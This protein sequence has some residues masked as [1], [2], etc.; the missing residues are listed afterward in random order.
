MQLT[1]G[2]PTPVPLAPTVMSR[3]ATATLGLSK[4]EMGAANAIA[5]AAA[6]ALN[7]A[8]QIG[9]EFSSLLTMLLGMAQGDDATPL[10]D[11]LLSLGP[12]V[13]AELATP[14]VRNV[15]LYVHQNTP[16]GD[17]VASVIEKIARSPVVGI[18]PDEFTA[19]DQL[20]THGILP[21][22]LK[23]RGVDI[24]ND[25]VPD[26]IQCPHCRRAFVP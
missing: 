22:L 18:N 2:V 21:K 14:V 3:V 15:L 19:V 5:S 24:D 20:I 13:L 9:N 26:L 25:G 16:Y 6:P 12:D 1:R 11:K 8:P 7:V 10:M 17:A 23:G 4:D